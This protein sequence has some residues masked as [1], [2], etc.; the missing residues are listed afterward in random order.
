MYLRSVITTRRV[1]KST[2]LKILE[3]QQRLRWISFAVTLKSV[4]IRSFFGPYFP[5]FTPNSGKCGPEKTP[6]LDTFHVV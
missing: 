5:V 6:Y 4:Q 2:C 3:N 1:L